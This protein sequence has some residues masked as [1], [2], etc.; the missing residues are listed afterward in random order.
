MRLYIEGLEGVITLENIQLNRLIHRAA[1]GDISAMEKIFIGMKDKIYSFVLMYVGN[2]QTA[3]DI[4][5]ETIIDVFSCAGSY[6]RFDN[7]K[8]WILTIA[9]NKAV[10][11]IRAV[12]KETALDDEI[13]LPFTFENEIDSKLNVISM[14]SGLSL[15]ERE[16]IVLH[17]ISGLKHKEIAKLLNLPIGTVCWK[18]NDAIK[19]L[20]NFSYSE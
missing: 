9:R 10:S 2:Q 16:I 8:A 7:P 12:S 6:K 11:S 17:V 19:K 18:Y 1:G 15:Q 5:Q 20:R 4:L 13:S 3:E 14:L